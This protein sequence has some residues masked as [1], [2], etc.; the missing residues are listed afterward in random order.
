MFP[1]AKVSF[2]CLTI[3]STYF[4][5]C[6]LFSVPQCSAS[7]YNFLSLFSSSSDCALPSLNLLSSCDIQITFM[8]FFTTFYH[9]FQFI[10]PLLTFLFIPNHCQWLEVWIQFPLATTLKILFH[11]SSSNTCPSILLALTSIPTNPYDFSQ[12]TCVLFYCSSLNSQFFS[13]PNNTSWYSCF[14]SFF[15]SPF[16]PDN[17]CERMQNIEINLFCCDSQ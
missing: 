9:I 2:R 8:P 13:S 15:L 16:L 5:P 4:K 12:K 17:N 7:T 10:L 3:P 11:L 14:M 1:C 6:L